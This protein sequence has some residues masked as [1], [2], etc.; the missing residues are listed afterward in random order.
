MP[1]FKFPNTPHFDPP[2]GFDHVPRLCTPKDRTANIAVNH[3]M[4][5][6]LSHVGEVI[7]AKYTATNTL[8]ETGTNC[9]HYGYYGA[10]S[11]LAVLV[12]NVSKCNISKIKTEIV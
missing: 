11:T 4:H 3:S 10:K 9:A 1:L 12:M 2:P 5:T 6:P 8:A 7:T